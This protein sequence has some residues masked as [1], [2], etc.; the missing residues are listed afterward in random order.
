MEI[1]SGIYKITNNINHRFYIGSSINIYKRWGE[2][3]RTL[4]KN[5]HDNDFLQKSWNKYGEDHFKFEIIELI[6]DKTELIIREQF[7]LDLIKPFNKNITYNICKIAGNMLGFKHSEKTKKILSDLHKGNKYSLGF[8]HSDMTKDKM[9]KS[10]T[11][12]KHNLETINKMISSSIGR[13]QSDETKEKL[14]IINK[15]KTATNKVKVYQLDLNDNIIKLWDSITEAANYFNITPSIISS[16][17]NGRNK[18]TSGYKW[19]YFDEQRPLKLTVEIKEEIKN[20]YI[21]G[22]YSIRKLSEIY[23]ISKS[24][25]WNIVK[26]N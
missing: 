5:I 19:L 22:E 21:S 26:N 16:V 17:C 4:R 25:I 13:T 9:S 15:G 24:T 7:Y 3:K 12:K 1:K 23:N 18:T 10:K 11:G 6:I 14:S 20:K 2:H 8:K